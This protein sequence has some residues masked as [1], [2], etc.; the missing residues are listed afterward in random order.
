MKLVSALGLAGV[1]ISAGS[2]VSADL[3]SAQP[4]LVIESAP[5]FD[6]T[7]FYA[8]VN[9]G[10]GW[11]QADT[12][13]GE[14]DPKGWLAGAQAGYNYAYGGFVL[15]AEADI[16]WSDLEGSFTT[17]L[18][19]VVTADL[20]AFGTV[21]GR[22]GLAIDRL[23]PYLTAGFAYGKMHGTTSFAPGYVT[24]EWVAGWTAGGGIEYAATDNILVRAEYLYVDYGPEVYFA[25]T[26]RQETVN[27]NFG[28][29]RLGINFK[30]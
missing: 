10:H 2:A 22:A 18:G 20:E 19:T 7:G 6:W 4:Q 21:R 12:L 23:M 28:A 3:Y 1:M 13:F 8:G 16:Q 25:G 29:A 26:P 24:D 30:F 9:G 14:L 5:Q 15:G 17:A 11:G 27:T